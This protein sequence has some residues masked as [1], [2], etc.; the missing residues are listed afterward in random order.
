VRAAERLNRL[1]IQPLT[2]ERRAEDAPVF[3]LLWLQDHCAPGALNPIV[4][5]DDRRLI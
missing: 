5:V 2:V 4:D 1:A 3:T